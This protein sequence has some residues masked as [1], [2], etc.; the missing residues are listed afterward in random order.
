VKPTPTTA[1]PQK[2][3]DKVS[4]ENKDLA[5]VTRRDPTIVARIW[6]VVEAYTAMVILDHYMQYIALQNM[7]RPE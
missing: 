6:P 7:K 4:L 5:A 3:I 2:T 1:K